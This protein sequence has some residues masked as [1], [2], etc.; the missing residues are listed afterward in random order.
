MTITTLLIPSIS[1]K[2]KSLV[3]GALLVALLSTVS[4]HAED[5]TPAPTGMFGGAARQLHQQNVEERK[6]LRN[7]NQEMRQEMMQDLIKTRK[8]II[9][10]NKAERESF[11]NNAKD[12]LEGKTA[13]ERRAL[14][15]TIKAE[16]QA[17][18][19]QNKTQ[20]QE[21]RK[22]AWDS[23]KTVTENVRTN[24]DSFQAT[25]RSRWESLWA[26]FKK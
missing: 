24:I 8:G 4:V 14:M 11:R 12:M 15:P 26:S 10:E 16:R 6:N 9:E 13:E 1:M 22:M 7:T 21:Y 3:L 5:I 25:V 19:E 2:K 23:K 20:L 17:L 18:G